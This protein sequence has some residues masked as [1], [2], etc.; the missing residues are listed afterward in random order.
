M[1]LEHLGVAGELDAR[2]Y[3]ERSQLLAPRV[4]RLADP[5]PRSPS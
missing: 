2:L 4:D 5:T 1:D 3:E